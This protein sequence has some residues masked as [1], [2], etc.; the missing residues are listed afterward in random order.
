MPY[1]FDVE[2]LYIPL[3]ISLCIL[4]LGTFQVTTKQLV[5][6]INEIASL[7]YNPTKIAHD[8]VDENKA[9]SH[10]K[11]LIRLNLSCSL[12]TKKLLTYRK[13]SCF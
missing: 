2:V 7:L 6:D 1:F 8:N 4:I 10:P 9:V 12:F 11:V 5:L 13:K 3:I